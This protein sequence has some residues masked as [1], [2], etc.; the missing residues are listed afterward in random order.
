MEEVLIE[1]ANLVSSCAEVDCQR[2]DLSA[3]CEG[4]VVQSI[5]LLLH[6]LCY[7]FAVSYSSFPV[8][9]NEIRCAY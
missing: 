1:A 3:I 4:D 6:W 5:C 2:L 9:V 7:I 8:H